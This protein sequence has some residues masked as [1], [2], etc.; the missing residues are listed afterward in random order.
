MSFDLITDPDRRREAQLFTAGMTAGAN[1]GAAVLHGLVAT[2][3]FPKAGALALLQEARAA[4]KLIETP[5]GYERAVD[6]LFDALAKGF[7]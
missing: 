7:S 2:G 5:V 4:S 3:V 1:V 6:D